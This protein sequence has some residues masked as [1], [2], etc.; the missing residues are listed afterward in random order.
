MSDRV[1]CVLTAGPL[2]PALQQALARRYRII[3]PWR[4]EDRQKLLAEQG[5]SVEAIVT[6]GIHG[7]NAELIEQLP[8][9]RAI[10]CFGVGVDA[11]D[12]EAA[13][14]RNVQVSNT[15]D[16][17]NNCVADSAMALLLAVA[18]Q[19][20]SADRFVRDERWGQERFGLTQA[21]G[22]KTCGIVGMGPIGQAIAHRAQAFGMKVM[23]NARSPKP[24][25]PYAYGETLVEL[26]LHS[27]FLVL[28]VP[29]GAATSGLVGREVLE[30]L[31]PGGILINVARGTVVDQPALIE[32][33]VQ[34]RLG[35]AGLDVFSNE[36]H[37]P[38]A[39]RQLDNVVLSPHI[40]SGTVETRQA[41][42]DRVLANLEALFV[43]G[44]VLHSVVVGIN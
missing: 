39:L 41:M 26:A 40:A 24:E 30:A 11:V 22:G 2:L 23:Y 13:R 14:A 21:L 42:A 8:A 6:T 15:P 35:G 43:N 7:A 38:Q 16:V 4:S 5:A 3:E 19:V 10:I 34:G 17:L 18:R 31:G 9:L 1:P 36:P 28:A 32:A 33:L 44:K 25:L 20:V 37:V 29:G 27:D 12:L